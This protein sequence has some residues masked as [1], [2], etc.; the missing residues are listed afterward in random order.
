[1]IYQYAC[2]KCRKKFDVVKS[3]KDIDTNEVCPRDG[4]PAIREFVP[5]KV[6]I[7]GAKVTHAEFNPGLGAIVKNEHHKRE[8]MKRKGVVEV[9]NDFGSGEKMQKEFDT[10]RTTKREKEWEAL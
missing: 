7:N 5:T 1:M 9:G 3:H 8:L 6:Y 4:H 2:T 10:A